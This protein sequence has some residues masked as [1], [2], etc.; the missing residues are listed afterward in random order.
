MRMCVA[1]M[2]AKLFLGEPACRNREWLK[3]SINFSIEL[4]ACAFILRKVPKFLH[5]MVAPLFPLRWRVAS[6]LERS[7]VIVGPLMERHRDCVQRRIAGEKVEEEDTLL[8]WMMDNG[9][10]E[11]NRLEQMA[12]R[13]TILTLAS[14]HTTSMAVSNLLFDL[15][16][17]PQWF[18]VLREEIAVIERDLGKL[19]ERPG[20]GAKQ[21]LPRLEKLDS[22][23]IE[24]LRLSPPLLRTLFSFVCDVSPADM[25]T[26]GNQRQVL[27]P[28][29]LKDGTHIPAGTRIACAKAD[30]VYNNPAE[31]RIFDP[32]RS[33]R[34]RYET[35][36][37]NKHLAG[38]LEKEYQHFGYGRQACPGRFFAIGEVKMMMVKLLDEFEFKFPPGKGRPN[39]FH[40]DEFAFLNPFAKLMI[41][42]RRV[43][44]DKCGRC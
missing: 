19:G 40:A 29:T 30:V 35:G 36:E 42:K 17:N 32:M 18:P 9:T 28:I 5:P 21:W 44:C 23:L 26:V 3:L 16:A 38:M 33:Y 2:T 34:K 14:I 6:T 31:F 27:V 43:A 8:N 39:I 25:R 7:R 12:S 10:E 41:R 20:I 24:S 11:E 37:L 13:Q 1:R 22:A 4:F 15:C